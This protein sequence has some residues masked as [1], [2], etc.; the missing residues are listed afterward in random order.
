MLDARGLKDDFFAIWNP[1]WS[2]EKAWGVSVRP[3]SYDWASS[4]IVTLSDCPSELR[5]RAWCA[6]IA[7]GRG[8]ND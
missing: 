4:T 3:A 5:W 6:W 2:P 1:G 7:R 8:T